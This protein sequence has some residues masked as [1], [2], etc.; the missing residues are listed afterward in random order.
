MPAKLYLTAVEEKYLI[1]LFHTELGIRALAKICKRDMYKTV[2][3][4]WVREFGESGLT[5]R[6][7]KLN[8][9]HKL[10]D[11]NPMY[12][13][14]HKLH[15]M[16]KEGKLSTQGY[17]ICDAPDWYT[18]K[19]CGSSCALEHTI[20]YCATNNLTEIPYKHVVHHLDGSRINNKP[21]NLV[22]LTISDHMRL[23]DNLK[24]PKKC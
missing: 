5:E 11:K 4:L 7:S 20:V 12:G 6:C 10:G 23:H 13:K 9:I 22:M 15:H 24:N 1:D 19:L 18:G 2:R 21:E 14:T 8:R 3:P 17:K 16:Y